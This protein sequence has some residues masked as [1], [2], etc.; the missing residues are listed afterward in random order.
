MQHVPWRSSVRW[1]HQESAR[2]TGHDELCRTRTRRRGASLG[3]RWLS[4]AESH[5]A[6][7][8]RITKIA[9]RC[10]SGTGRKE[11]ERCGNACV[12]G[13]NGGVPRGGTP[14]VRPNGR[15]D[16]LGLDSAGRAL[17]RRA[18]SGDQLPDVRWRAIGAQEPLVRRSSPSQS[19]ARDGIGGGS[20]SRSDGCDDFAI[21]P[22]TRLPDGREEL[23]L[24]VQ[25]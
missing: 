4:V 20:G 17:R 23:R 11:G 6:E 7:R 3:R 1:R 10:L 13:G 21:L 14:I 8:D 5:P 16:R 2:R 15:G 18:A 24:A 22:A 19:R 12:T 9:L 25:R